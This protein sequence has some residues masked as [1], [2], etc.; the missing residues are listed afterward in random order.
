MK[1]VTKNRKARRSPS[2]PTLPDIHPLVRVVTLLLFIAGIS[3]ARPP[4]LVAGLILLAGIY[5]VSGF[6]ALG[7]L[8][9]LLKRLRWLMLT[10]VLVYGWWTPGEPLFTGHEMLSPT[11]EGVQQGFFRVLVLF[12]IVAAVHLLLQKTGREQLIAALMQLFTPLS[13]RQGRERIAVRIVLSMEAVS[14]IQPLLHNALS[15]RSVLSRRLSGLGHVAADIYGAVLDA[16]DRE[17]CDSIT[18]VEAPR[19]ALWQWLIPL[20][21]V[22]GITLLF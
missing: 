19:P 16:A 21:L 15:G 8:M 4:L 10:I 11:V 9:V 1:R 6:P 17:K 13:S 20:V 7:K 22:A 12:I 14:Q 2:F 5:L 18:V 3:L